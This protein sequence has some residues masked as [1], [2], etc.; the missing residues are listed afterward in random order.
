VGCQPA[1]KNRDTT[2]IKENKK[3]RRSIISVLFVAAVGVLGAC[4]TTPEVKP[5]PNVAPSPAASPVASPSALPTIDPKA[6]AVPSAKLPAL[7]GVWPGV[8]G[9]S[10][11]IIRKSDKYAIE[12][13]ASGKTDTFEGVVKGD[14][15]E[16]K[17]KDKMETIKAATAEETGMKWLA[18]E[19]TCVVITKGSEGYCR[20]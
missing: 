11:N 17:R 9:S 2:R 5:V 6:P 4:T 15:I 12:I 16:F 13:K 14:T 18:G 7:E 10:L 20:K 1:G 19:K 8:D 3:M